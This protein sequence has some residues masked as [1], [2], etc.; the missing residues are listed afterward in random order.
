MK[1]TYVIKD[2]IGRFNGF[3]GIYSTSLTNPNTD[4]AWDYQSEKY[5]TRGNLFRENAELELQKLQEINLIAGYPLT[6]EVVEMTHDE[7]MK[8]R[9]DQLEKDAK[10]GM[11]EFMSNHSNSS[12]EYKEIEKGC[13]G[14]HRKTVNEINKKFENIKRKKIA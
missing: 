14:K 12:F 4:W 5:P 6:W 10:L 2:S 8:L 11:S 9:E 3:I 1:N 13:I 7:K